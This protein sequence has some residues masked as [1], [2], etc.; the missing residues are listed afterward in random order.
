[1]KTAAGRRPLYQIHLSTLM[2]Q[3]ML[4]GFLLLLQFDP[5]LKSTVDF[6][7]HTI[8]EA[9]LRG[10]P[11]VQSIRYPGP[12]TRERQFTG[13][14]RRNLGC[15]LA[16]LICAF[17]LQ[18]SWLRRRKPLF[19]WGRSVMALLLTGIVSWCVWRACREHQTQEFVQLTAMEC[20][21]ND[22]NPCDGDYLCDSLLSTAGVD[23]VYLSNGHW[24]RAR[25][26]KVVEEQATELNAARGWHLKT[27]CRE[28]ADLWVF[29]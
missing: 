17:F 8:Q 21:N 1:M 4:L 6:K 9:E 5:T 11:E 29:W 27:E 28:R 12:E 23:Y 14:L 16:I 19:T 25:D 3:V 15:M 22:L 10:W 13:P 26:L 7:C 24:L 18:E 20:P 2:V